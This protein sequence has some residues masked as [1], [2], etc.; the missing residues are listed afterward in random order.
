MSKTMAIVAAAALLAAA[1]ANAAQ[2]HKSKVTPAKAAQ[3]AHLSWGNYQDYRG[4]EHS[5]GLYAYA[6]EDAISQP[7]TVT[8][9]PMPY[10]A[11]W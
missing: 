9:F 5:P 11:W 3:T 2:T 1:S 6:R 8:S 10:T 4:F 7:M